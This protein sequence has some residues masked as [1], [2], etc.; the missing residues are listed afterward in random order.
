MC[1]C[2][3]SSASYSEFI[4]AKVLSFSLSHSLSYSHI[5][6]TYHNDYQTPENTNTGVIDINLFRFYM[7]SLTRRDDVNY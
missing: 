5:T 7:P 4:K 6:Q 3:C 1:V 2:V